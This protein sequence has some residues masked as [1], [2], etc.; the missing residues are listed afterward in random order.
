MKGLSG[1][2]RLNRWRVDEKRRELIGLENMRQDLLVRRTALDVEI[3]AE[4]H[5]ADESVV[6]YAYGTY[7][8]N[9]LR[10]RETLNKSIAEV[11]AAIT[12]KQRE[13]GEAVQE[14]KKIEIAADRRAERERLEMNR[15]DQIA[16]DEIALNVYRQQG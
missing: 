1:L 9:A 2:I 3:A 6:Q 16:M 14:L 12:E 15:R 10:R 13:V 5:V 4:Q 11:E 7:V 8:K